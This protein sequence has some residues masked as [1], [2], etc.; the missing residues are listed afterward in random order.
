MK[1]SE[2][3]KL[4]P[5]V[6]RVWVILRLEEILKGIAA[7]K[8]ACTAQDGR[9]AAVEKYLAKQRATKPFVLGIFTT[10]GAL[11]G[12]AAVAAIRFILMN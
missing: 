3:E 2:T 10:L 1:L 6:F 8:T 12:G 5:R 7:V 4:S 11:I 9:I